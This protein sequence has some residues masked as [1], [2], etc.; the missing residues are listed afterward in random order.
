MRTTIVIDGML[1][2]HARQAVQTA[3]QGVPGLAQAHVELGRAVL[4]HA[5]P[6][7]EGA[8]REAIGWA[9]CAVVSLTVERRVLPTGA[10]PPEG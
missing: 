10:P 3:L 4:E 6:L 5:A 8:V 7:D 9:G 1:S 2:A